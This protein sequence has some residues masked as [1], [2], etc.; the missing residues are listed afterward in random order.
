MI[1]L[2]LTGIV[3]GIA[4][5]FFGIGGGLIIVPALVYFNGFSQHKATGTSLAALLL[6]VGFMAVYEY[7]RKGNIDWRAAMIIGG[8]IVFGSWASAY[9]TNVKVKGPQ[10]QLA[11]GL[12]AVVMGGYTIWSAMEKMRAS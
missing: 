6:P 7:H 9:F 11:F 5:G 1:V 10:L 12:F 4:A 8:M 2:L 3:A